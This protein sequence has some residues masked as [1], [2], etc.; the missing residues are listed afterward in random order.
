MQIG[1]ENLTQNST[2]IGHLKKSCFIH[3]VKGIL[4]QMYETGKTP[5]KDCTQFEDRFLYQK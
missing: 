5:L 4:L 2:R 3:F 1:V